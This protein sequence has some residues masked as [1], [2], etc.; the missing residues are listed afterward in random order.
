MKL[1][2]HPNKPN[3]PHF[4]DGLDQFL[5]TST[6]YVK[7]V[8]M[9]NVTNQNLDSSVWILTNLPNHDKHQ[10]IPYAPWSKMIAEE[11]INLIFGSKQY[12]ACAIE[13]NPLAQKCNGRAMSLYNFSIQNSFLK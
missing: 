2:K 6:T 7:A 1:N 8:T 10:H 11:C 3:I 4:I 5:G 13:A 12:L 9:Y